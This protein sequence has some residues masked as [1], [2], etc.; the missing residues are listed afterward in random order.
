MS[1]IE[2]PRNYE[3]TTRDREGGGHQGRGRDLCE[4]FILLRN[5]CSQLRHF[6]ESFGVFHGNTL[7]NQEMLSREVNFFSQAV[8]AF[9]DY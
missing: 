9:I 4:I 8:F 6:L 2:L 3:T 7:L 1:L 5:H